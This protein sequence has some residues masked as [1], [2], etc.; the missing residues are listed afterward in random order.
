MDEDG[1]V[2]VHGTGFDI[3][4]VSESTTK[5]FADQPLGRFDEADTG[6]QTHE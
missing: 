4:A 3:V 1:E 5:G 6:G 2:V